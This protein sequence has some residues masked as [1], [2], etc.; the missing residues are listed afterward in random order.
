MLR[1]MKIKNKRN[2]SKNKDPWNLYL[3]RCG[4]GSLYTGITKNLTQR[5]EKHNNG[6]GATYTRTHRP[7]RLIYQ[8]SC[9]DRTTALIRELKVKSM[10]RKEKEELVSATV[11]I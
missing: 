1:G 10:S 5:L 7:V 8:E 11:G 4:D 6:K 9:A 3:L 2:R